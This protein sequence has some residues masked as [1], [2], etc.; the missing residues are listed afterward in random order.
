MFVVS[1]FVLI[2]D[3]MPV[4]LGNLPPGLSRTLTGMTANHSHLQ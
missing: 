1:G 4:S 3:S 2:L